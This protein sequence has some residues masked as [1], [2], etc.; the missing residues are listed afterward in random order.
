MRSNKVL[1]ARRLQIKTIDDPEEA[2]PGDW[3]VY[4]DH[5]E[6]VAVP[7]GLFRLLFISIEG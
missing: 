7:D 4:L 2:K 3:I 6:R 1:R 5:N